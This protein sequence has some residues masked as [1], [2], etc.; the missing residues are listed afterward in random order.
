MAV[1][2][3]SQQIAQKYES[4]EKE[5]EK[6]PT[7]FS[8]FGEGHVFGCAYLK[9]KCGGNDA[10]QCNVVFSAIYKNFYVKIRKVSSN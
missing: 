7:Q 8:T 3:S 1:Q 6:N 2:S 5:K 9:R 4:T 10:S